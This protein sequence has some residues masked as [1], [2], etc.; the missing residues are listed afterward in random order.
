VLRGTVALDPYDLRTSGAVMLA[1]AAVLPVLPGH[2]ELGC[3]LRRL[4]GIP[5]PLCG[6]TTSVEATVRLHL[7]R[8]FEANPAGIAAVLVALVLLVVR[9]AHVRIPAALLPGL[10]AGLWLFELHSFSIL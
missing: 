6:M 10:L 2:D 9:P 5:C 8:A 1:A 3:P 4:T 7:G